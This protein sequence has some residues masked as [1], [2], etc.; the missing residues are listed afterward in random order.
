MPLAGEDGERVLAALKTAFRTCID[1]TPVRRRVFYDTFD[2]RLAGDSGV[3]CATEAAGQ[4][5]L[6]W[7]SQTGAVLRRLRTEREPGFTWDLP[8][9]P[10]R[11]ALEPI[12]EMRRLLPLAEVHGDAVALRVLD[13]K[14]KTVA[15][16]TLERW[17]ARH[18]GTASPV[19][20]PEHLRVSA[21]RGY[22]KRFRRLLQFLEQELGLKRGSSGGPLAG[23]PLEARPRV[24]SK[25]WIPLEP[26]LRS[27]E[28]V[29]RIHRVLLD[30]M[31]RNED[32]TRLD[33]D[34]EFLHDFR[35]AIRRTRGALSQLRGVFPSAV[36][37]H[38]KGEF[39]WLGGC[40]GPTRDLDVYLLKLPSYEAAV[41][42]AAR[43]HLAP[44]REHLVACQRTAQAELAAALDS[45]RYRRLI[46]AW[47]RFLDQP[48]P[49]R[50][51]LPDAGRP[52]RAFAAERILR[53]HRK[54]VKQG[55]R[56]TDA[57]PADD[58]HDVRL[59]CK[60]L[61][62]LMEFTRAVFDRK[63]IDTQ[64]KTLKRLQENLGDFNDLEVQAASLGTMAE[65]MA[66]AG[67][68]PVETI[69]TMGRLTETFERGQQEER[70]R[71][72]T[73][74]AEFDAPEC[75]AR[76]RR[77]FAPRNEPGETQ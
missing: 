26:G 22:E 17:T 75:R 30:A 4:S 25:L 41:A 70:R 49:R 73:R 24:S 48:V 40:T 31:L 69:M 33:L 71:F 74:F 11:D 62:Y 1:E 63:D 52:I 65:D 16:L 9:G 5:D 8:E 29:K 46:E 77:L 67:R 64:I 7:L 51:M 47:A 15:R 37:E 50:S 36:E 34:S 76:V 54:I 59:R 20:L 6:L 38:F 19:R 66:R 58:L 57:S 44:L 21:V 13:S 32:G 28:A 35:V 14:D 27:D 23:L 60:K 18:E 12:V 43:P 56:I 39:R 42:R 3:L 53:V 10:F 68:A 72:A 61:R 55:R 2:R 45:D